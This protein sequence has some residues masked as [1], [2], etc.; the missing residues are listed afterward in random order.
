[1]TDPVTDVVKVSYAVPVSEEQLAD[2]EHWS[3]A[4]RRWMDATPE[5]REQWRREA[6]AKRAQE[7]ANAP[8][9]PLTVAALLDKLGW[10]PQY[11]VH[12][13]QPY[14]ECSDGYDGWD[15]CEHAR[16][17]GLTP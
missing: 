7:R 15:Y 16:D 10:S 1:M 3:A 11:A 17:E 12:F 4:Y 8:H 9:T 14:C 5:E 13:V 6:E 2:A